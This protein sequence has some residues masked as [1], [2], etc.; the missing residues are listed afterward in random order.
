MHE[1]E[2][3]LCDEQVVRA[4][5]THLGK[6]A[7][8]A[9]TTFLYRVR[10]AFQGKALNAIV[11][12]RV[13]ARVGDLLNGAFTGAQIADELSSTSSAHG[14]TIAALNLPTRVEEMFTEESRRVEAALIEGGIGMLA[15]LPGKHLMSIL[16]NMLGFGK[17]VELTRLVIESLNR[18]HLDGDAALLGLQKKLHTALSPYLP[19]RL[20]AETD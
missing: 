2:S 6:S 16:A 17:T 4:L 19:P 15:I 3:I 13:R 5:A 9:W 8:E 18:R 10:A 20:A 11:A 1:L 7:D 12:R 14:A